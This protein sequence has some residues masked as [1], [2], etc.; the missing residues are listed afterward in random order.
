MAS[1]FLSF[2]LRCFNGLRPFLVESRHGTIVQ[3]KVGKKAERRPI[4]M[5]N[6]RTEDLSNG[7]AVRLRD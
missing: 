6:S 2:S 7:Q 1:P 5:S 3:F 4:L